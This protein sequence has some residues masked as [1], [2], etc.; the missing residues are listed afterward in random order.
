MNAFTLPTISARPGLEIGRATDAGRKYRGEPNQDTLLVLPAEAGRPSLVIVADGMGGHAGGAEASHI[1]A[2]SVA[3]HYRTRKFPFDP[4]TFLKECLGQAHQDLIN[5]VK[6]HPGLD[7]MGSTAVVAL[8]DDG[9]AFVANVGD[10]RAYLL[11]GRSMTQLSYD[12]SVVADL[13]RAGQM[14]PLQALQSPVRN[15]LTQSISPKRKEIAPHLTRSTF[16]NGDILVLCTD[17]LWGVVTEAILQ[18]VAS[19]LPP[20]AAAE[21]LINLTLARGAP[22]NVTVVITRR[23]GSQAAQAAESEGTNPGVQRS[24]C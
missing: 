20:Q 12:H 19:E 17:G 4:S 2:E 14:T 21:K 15:R 22:D 18:A 9:Q 13:V 3:A 6:T 10:S 24:G 16:G 5:Y 23:H 8:I 7:S 1:V 11:H